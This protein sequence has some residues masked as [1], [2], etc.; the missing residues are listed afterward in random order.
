MPVTSA[1]LDV[2]IRAEVLNGVWE[3]FGVDR[4]VEVMP[5]TVSYEADS[6]GC[7]KASFT[8]RRNPWAAWPDLSPFT[9]IEIEIGG[10]IVWIGRTEGTPLKAGAEAQI[11][12][13]CGGW[14]QHLDDNLYKRVYVHSMLTDWKD[15]RSSL[16][17]PLADW[18][19]F[20]QV[21]V[22][23]GSIKLTFPKGDTVVSG[24]YN[25]GAYVD[26]GE[27]AAA[28]VAVTF[29]ETSVTEEG[30]ELVVRSAPTVG[31]ITV[32][33]GVTIATLNPKAPTTIVAS[34]ATLN[35]YLAIFIGRSGATTT[36]TTDQALAISGVNVFNEGVPEAGGVSYLIASQVIE[37]A[38]NRAPLLS[39]DRSQIDPY[40]GTGQP[41]LEDSFA[42]PSLVLSSPQTPRQVSESM[43]SFHDWLLFVDLERRLN[44]RPPPTEPLL[45]YGAWSGEQ[46][47][48]PSAGEAA[49]IY[50]SVVVTGVAANGEALEVT[51]TA[52]ELGATT[53]VGE[54][55]FTRAKTIS[56]SNATDE[57]V[58]RKIGEVWLEDQL[59]TPFG[60]AI[61]VP[62]GGLRTV[63]GGAPSHP[64][65]VCRHVNEPLRVA[66][67]IDPN[68]GGVGRDG[69]VVAASY[70]HA[71]QTATVTLGARLDAV[72]ALLA[73]LAVVQEQGS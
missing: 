64:S 71:T 38:A 56:L 32:G 27:P 29:G 66:H 6:W 3:T 16:E 50:S 41:E 25:V 31:D 45:E 65:L 14:S 54:R 37:D 34:T 55:G 49:D 23:G 63:L 36:P 30:Y 20:P 40:A 10:V 42:I 62:V 28:T 73:R 33:G 48:S 61:T 22:E 67:A 9:P 43:N 4:D 1:T 13:Q 68:T 39:L 57:T 70:E 7:L 11:N 47:E 18:P 2:S 69:F 24:D 52:A 60:G 21:Q 17:T 12:V 51:V 44:F 8:L 15:M 59:V 53:V 58:M 26:L 35:R 72:E 5:E 19:A 46:V